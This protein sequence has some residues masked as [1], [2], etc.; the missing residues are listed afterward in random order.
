MTAAVYF[1]PRELDPTK[2]APNLNL[3]FSDMIPAGGGP[4][5]RRGSGFSS[6]LL[7]LRPGPGVRDLR[8]CSDRD[9]GAGRERGAPRVERADLGIALADASGMPVLNRYRRVIPSGRR[10]SADAPSSTRQ[11][12]TSVALARRA[13]VPL[14]VRDFRGAGPAGVRAPRHRSRRRSAVGAWSAAK[15][16]PRSARANRAHRSQRHTHRPRGLLAPQA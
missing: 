16:P 3:W 9:H 4:A 6:R 5:I 13:C 15:D 12:A 8:S 2:I 10:P 14:P 1:V 11:C 7:D